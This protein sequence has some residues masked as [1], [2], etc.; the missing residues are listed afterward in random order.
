MEA[1]AK[2]SLT[3]HIGNFVF[4][5]ILGTEPKNRIQSRVQIEQELL[6]ILKA[7]HF[8][9]NDVVNLA[10]FNYLEEKGRK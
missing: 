10:L 3:S 1:A 9:I 5:R 4:R 8:N 7:N 2:T 6:T